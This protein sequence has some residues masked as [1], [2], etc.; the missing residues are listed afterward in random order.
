[1]SSTQ[2]SRSLGKKSR[3]LSRFDFI[4]IYLFE[5][6]REYSKSSYKNDDEKDALSMVITGY[7]KANMTPVLIMTPIL[8]FVVL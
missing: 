8:T 3:P 4:Y 2:F 1:V 6:L 5:Y 7:K